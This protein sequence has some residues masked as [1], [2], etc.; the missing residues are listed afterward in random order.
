MTPHTC[1]EKARI[2]KGQSTRLNRTP[3]P[4]PPRLPHQTHPR[5]CR[6]LRNASDLFPPQTKSDLCL[7][8]AVFFFFCFAASI[9]LSLRCMTAVR[10]GPWNSRLLEDFQGVISGNHKRLSGCVNWRRG[11]PGERSDA[12]ACFAPV[13]VI[14]R[15][16][17]RTAK[18]YP[19][20]SC[21]DS[22][23]I[24]IQSAHSATTDFFFFNLIDPIVCLRCSSVAPRSRHAAASLHHPSE[25]I[26]ENMLAK[27][28][29]FFS[30]PNP[31]KK[32]NRDLFCFAAFLHLPQCD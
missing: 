10:Q 28:C 32:S 20:L 22:L 8:G 17:S 14:G 16:K 31:R 12:A 2:A 30:H 6:F 24:L 15:V 3:H 11:A 4:T 9:F 26:T 25:T 5:T 18:Y 29:S 7:C 19:A 27:L 21:I 23:L 1:G 13:T